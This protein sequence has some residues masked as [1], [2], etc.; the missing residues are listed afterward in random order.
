[1]SGNEQLKFQTGV[2]FIPSLGMIKSPDSVQKLNLSEQNI[3]TFL[4]DNHDRPVTKQE[5]LQAGWPDRTVTEASLFQVIRALRVKL[6]EN[7]KGDVIETLPRVGYQITQ[8]ERLAF[9]PA[10][11]WAS[12]I[13][14]LLRKRWLILASISLL[15]LLGLG[16]YWWQ[17]QFR[18]SRQADYLTQDAQWDNAALTLIA[19]NNQDLEELQNKLAQVYRKHK[20]HF[21][22]DKIRDVKLYAYKGDGLYSIAWCLVDSNQACLP[23]TDYSYTVEDHNWDKLADF[24]ATSEKSEYKRTVIESDKAREPTSQVFIHYLDDSGVQS[25]IIHHYLSIDQSGDLN[26][27]YLSFIT[28]QGTNYHQALSIR[29]A[30]VSI[31]ENHSPFLSTA[32]LKPGMFHWA[33]KAHDAIDEKQ[34][35]AFL[36]ETRLRDHYQ[37]KRIVYSYLLHRD[38]N[39]DLI[40]YPE[41]GVYWVHN[42]PDKIR[43][44]DSRR[45][46]PTAK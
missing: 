41:I 42:S 39:L 13:P 44:F 20:Q 22:P 21:S 40:F 37:A 36:T 1:M 32:K 6:Q 19:T 28:E 30:T 33:Y 43:L 12:K 16:T 18:S 31:V 7:H 24:L 25:K 2:Y 11:T 38:A 15:T 8:F 27:S 29:A 5:L 3:L 14:S 9:R 45:S 23:L 35:A 34:S 4:I 46:A 17:N 26:Y 10:G